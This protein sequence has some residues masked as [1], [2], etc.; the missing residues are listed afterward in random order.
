MLLK[1]LMNFC[2][3]QK[4]EKAHALKHIQKRKLMIII[5]IIIIIII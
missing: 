2:S 1:V 5:I 4:R 3:L